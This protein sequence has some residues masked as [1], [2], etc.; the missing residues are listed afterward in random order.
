MQNFSLADCDWIGF[1]LDHTLVRYKV[2][3][4]NR[5]IYDAMLKY[6]VMHKAATYEHPRP[7]YLRS[8]PFDSHFGGRGTFFDRQLG[9]M[10]KI[11]QHKRVVRGYHGL[12]R[13]LSSEELKSLYPEPLADA[14]TEIPE[15]RYWAL[16]TFF[17]VPA[18]YLIALLVD[19]VDETAPPSSSSAT[20][21]PKASAPAPA[22]APITAPTKQTYAGVFLDLVS[23]FHF[24]FGNYDGGWYFPVLKSV[25]AETGVPEIS[26]YIY[27]RDEVRAWLIKLRDRHLLP[28]DSSSSSS[29]AASSAPSSST[30]EGRRRRQR[31]F[32]VTNS[33][34]DYT[35]LL[36][37]YAFGSDWR[38]LFDI[39]VTNAGKAKFFE[40]RAPFTH[41]DVATSTDGPALVLD[42]AQP[43]A[44]NLQLGGL[45]AHGNSADLTEFFQRVTGGTSDSLRVIYF[46]DHLKTDVFAV[47]TYVA[48]TNFYF[49]VFFVDDFDFDHSK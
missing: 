14:V 8:I 38:T 41:V 13:R 34:Y 36:M 17:E 47:K 23:G 4:L 37:N 24:N 35:A 31:L 48:S 9:N 42:A 25:N 30:S 20:E 19:Y 49:D 10:L 3:A 2:D 18:A 12:H 39:V 16:I 45:Y 44:E 27:K 29:S 46:G 40:V 33:K 5:L 32:L 6:L 43:N 15:D 21:T 28:L 26:K 7:G 11:D 1:D 22:P